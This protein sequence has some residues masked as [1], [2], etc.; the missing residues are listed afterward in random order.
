MSA[1]QRPALEFDVA[2]NFPS[3]LADRLGQEWPV[4]RWK[5]LTVVVALSGGADSV[6]LLCGLVELRQKLSQSGELGA[7]RLIAAHLN[8]GLRGAESEEDARFCL[9]LC[10][11]LDLPLVVERVGIAL[12]S[13]S[14]EGLE[15]AARQERYKF[16]IGLAQQKGARYVVTAHTKNDQVETVLH[17]ILRGTGIAGLGGIPLARELSP[18]VSLRRP[19]R[20]MSR[21]EVL[22]YLN[23][24]GQRFRTDSSNASLD[25]TRNRIRH[26]LLP[27]LR[28]AFNLQVDQALL[29]L[30]EQA[31]ELQEMLQ[32]QLQEAMESATKEI[33]TGGVQ[34]SAPAL[35]KLHVWMQREVVRHAWKECQWPLRGMGAAEWEMLRKMVLVESAEVKR[36]DL[37]GGI[38]AEKKGEWLSLTHPSQTI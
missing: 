26:E 12:E 36:M 5:D 17:R 8:H 7:G 9:E 2:E 34:I 30:A 21:D 23:T 15:E 31:G 35:A 6:A 22:Q 25:F 38:R 11:T 14:K 37:P 1:K 28:Q 16:L 29:R 10:R 13:Q 27:W 18:G 33:A 4:E 19:M 3:N 32:G 20:N 24:L